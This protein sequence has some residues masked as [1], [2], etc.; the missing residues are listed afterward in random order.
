LI[1]SNPLVSVIVPTKNSEA[2]LIKCLE[3][4]K[5]QTYPNIE[6]ILVDNYSSDKTHEV[7]LKYTVRIYLK[8]P[9]RASQVN[10]GVKKAKGKYVYRVDSDF[11]LENSIIEEA[12]DACETRGYDAVAVHNTS[13][14]TVSFWA[15]VRKLERDCYKDDELNVGARFFKIDVFNA[16]GGFDETLVAAE[17]YDLHN[18]LLKSGFKIGRIRSS[19]THVGEPKTLGDIV[20][21]HYYYGKSIHKYV[22]KNPQRAKRQLVPLRPSYLKNKAQ[23]LNNPV[24]SVGFIIYQLV[25]YSA[26]AIGYFRIKLGGETC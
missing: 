13:D 9:E 1:A 23:F 8:G 6:I 4:I 24:L 20:R 22:K 21:K 7:A 18:R 11:V 3:S 16:V 2:T 5:N 15:K 25:R 12:V 17:D 14:P 19:E 10:F 26:T